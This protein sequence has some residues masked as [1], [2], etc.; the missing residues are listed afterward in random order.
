[1]LREMGRDLGRRDPLAAAVEVA[2]VRRLA[3]RQVP[4]MIFD[5][6]DGAADG[7]VTRRANV[8][9]FERVFLAPRGLVDVAT[10]DLA[11]TVLG[12]RLELPVVL[13]PTGMPG[14]LHPS[15]E[16]AAA[17]AAFAAGTAFC[18]STPSSY[19]VAEV[20]QAVGR[21]VWFQLYAWRDRGL[22]AELIAMARAAGCRTLLL[23]IDTPVVGRRLRD[24]RGGMSLPPRVTPANVRDA[25]LHPLRWARW[26]ARM[27][28]GPGVQLG[29]LKGLDAAPADGAVGVAAWLSSLF[30]PAQTWQDVEWLRTVWPGRIAIKGVL[31]P[32]DA[33]HARELGVDALIVSNHGG[34]QLDGAAPTL[35]V[36]PSI[37]EAVSGTDIEVLL[38]GGVRRGTDVLKALAF[39]ARACLI[40]RPWVWGLAAGGERGVTRVLEILREELDRALALTGCPRA[41]DV[42]A[43]V[44]H[45]PSPRV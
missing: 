24:V 42:D 7:E 44:L 39:G 32:Q 43:S 20:V 4:R 31:H 38:D 1:M 6:A 22:T 36:L 33:A 45:P 25:A 41:A 17:R 28:T 16:I 19:S 27:R 26:A 10:R 29:N 18:I 3:S 23:T 11:T 34:R 8:T 21:P 12:E 5:Y 35:D 37:V 15:A 40:G 2:D 14:L 30:N 9:A 13:G